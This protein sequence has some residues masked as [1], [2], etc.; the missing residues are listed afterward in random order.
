MG[1]VMAN[2]A[3]SP[4]RV[5]PVQARAGVVVTAECGASSPLANDANAV[6][7]PRL[8]LLAHRP[9]AGWSRP[10]QA[11]PSS[12]R[13]CRTAS[14]RPAC[15]AHARQSCLP[16][17]GCAVLSCSLCLQVPAHSTGLVF[18]LLGPAGPQQISRTLTKGRNYMV[19]HVAVTQLHRNPGVGAAACR[20][21]TTHPSPCPPGP[22]TPVS[23]L[24]ART[25]PP[26]RLPP[27][28]ASSGRYCTRRVSLEN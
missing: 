25:E 8:V 14:A 2:H 22:S 27:P 16:S 11:T 10:V 26:R 28:S 4:G 18:C 23:T 17:P 3:P 1:C 6:G 20:L 19:T 24:S 7:P 21:R 15:S 13:T 5:R 9:S 12:H